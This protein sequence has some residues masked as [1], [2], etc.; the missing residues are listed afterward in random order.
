M[1]VIEIE[2]DKKR[3]LQNQNVWQE[4]SEK[5]GF[6]LYTVVLGLAGENEALDQKAL[7]YLPDFIERKKANR[8]E[9]IVP[10]EKLRE[11]AEKYKYD[12]PARISIIPEENMRQIYDYFCFAFNLDNIA[13]TFLDQCPYN[14][15]GRILRETDITEEEAVCLGVYWL[16]ELK[17]KITD[18]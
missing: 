12:F 15:M 2:N 3:M 11:L 13:F 16:R 10:N 4:I 14:L 9:I 5:I 18:V 7:D 1:N 17:E 8:A 6:N